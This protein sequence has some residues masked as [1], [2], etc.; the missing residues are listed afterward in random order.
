MAIEDSIMYDMATWAA[1]LAYNLDAYWS[2]TKPRVKTGLVTKN[3]THPYGVTQVRDAYAY[4]IDWDQ[5]HA[6]KALARLWNKGYKV[7]SARKE[8]NNGSRTYSR[9]TLVILMG[10]N[11][12]KAKS[13]RSDMDQIAKEAGVMIDAFTTGRMKEGI[14]FGSGNLSLIHI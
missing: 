12:V 4:V 5:R 11:T 10:R 14:D 7:R 8:F 9:G 2:E 6:P 1:P 3:L 13:V